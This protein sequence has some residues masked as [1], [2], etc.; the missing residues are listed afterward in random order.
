M[1]Y[2]HFDADKFQE[3][4]QFVIDFKAKIDSALKKSDY[5]N[6]RKLSSQILHTIHDFYSHSNWVEMGKTNIL[7]TIGTASFNNQPV[8]QPKDANICNNNCKLVTTKCS[9]PL[10]AISNVLKQ[11]KPDITLACPVQYYKCDKNIVMLNKLVS[12]FYTDQELP[13]GTVVENPG[14]LMK[15]NHGGILDSNSYRKQALGGINKD[16]G[17]Y[18]ISP[19]ANLHLKAADLAVLHTEYFF[20]SIRTQIGDKAFSDFLKI[21]KFI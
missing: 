9:K 21:E 13:D 18:S 6:A 1:P 16:S 10:T 4:N 11:L 7:S 2:A 15:C 20:N 14:N 19:H 17:I 3:S 8:V 5:S 12:G